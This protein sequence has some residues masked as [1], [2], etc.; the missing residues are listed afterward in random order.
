MPEGNGAYV[1]AFVV[2]VIIVLLLVFFF[3]NSCGGSSLLPCLTAC[4]LCLKADSN[5]IQLGKCCEAKITNS[6]AQAT[7][8]TLPDPGADASFLLSVG[9]QSID[10]NKV[11]TTAGGANAVTQT[12]LKTDSVTINGV[13]GKITTVSL[14]EDGNAAAVSFT[15]KNSSVTA[16]SLVLASFSG[17]SGTTGAPT[18]LIDDVADGSFVVRIVNA[19]TAGTALNGALTISFLLL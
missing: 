5:Q 6:V 15:V 7:T 14:S 10:G 13:S 9:D 12:G 16:D 18:L 3:F 8:Y 1:A 2:I 11:V 17:Y 4:R 19:S